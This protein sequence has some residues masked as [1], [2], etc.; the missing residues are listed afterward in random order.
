MW[1]SAGAPEVE[2]TTWEFKFRFG[3]PARSRTPRP[4][5][6]FG[7]VRAW[8]GIGFLRM[9]LNVRRQ[10]L[11]AGPGTL[12]PRSKKCFSLGGES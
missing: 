3:R 1:D 8:V 7:A 6:K 10:S 5:T 12:Q 4:F 2:R 9:E 11:S